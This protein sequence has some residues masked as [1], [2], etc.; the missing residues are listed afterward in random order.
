MDFVFK[1]TTI[2]NKQLSNLKRLERLDFSGLTGH[3]SVPF[4]SQHTF[5]NV[6]HIRNLSLDMC[7]IRSLQRGTFHMMKNITFLDISGN[8]CLK[9]QV[10][11]NVTADLQFSAIKILKV[12]K[13]HKVFDMNTYLQTTHIKHLH[14][15]SIQ[16]VHMD[17]NRLQQVEPGALRF[18]PRTLIYL[19]V[20]D[21][22][23]SI[24]QYLYDLL[25]LSFETVDASE[26]IPFTRKIH[27]LKDAT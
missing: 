21:N 27:T 24:G 2:L 19:S 7:E 5:Q 1:N 11:E 26:C 16:E 8:T 22:M 18:L 23:F 20:K 9:F 14:N 13:I 3:C 10:L 12:N 15:T 6:P 17:S 25:T 4:L